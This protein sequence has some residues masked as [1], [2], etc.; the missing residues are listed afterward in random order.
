[1]SQ[2]TS[3]FN[4]PVPIQ[5][6]HHVESFNSGCDTLDTWLHEQA[7]ADQV[8]RTAMTYVSTDGTVSV[9]GFYTLKTGS[10]QHGGEMIPI[11]ILNRLAVASSARGNGLRSALLLD[12]VNRAI[13][14]AATMGFAA[15]VAP[16]LDEEMRALYLDAGFKPSATHPQD[17][18]LVL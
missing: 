7:K 9:Q 12:A 3:M 8:A 17:V 10:V 13:S 16:T 15:V 6:N 4:R 1:M 5:L 11:I 14:V 18:I 2:A